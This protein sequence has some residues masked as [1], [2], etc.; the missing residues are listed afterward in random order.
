[1]NQYI[2]IHSARATDLF[3][4]PLGVQVHMQLQHYVWGWLWAFY[5]GALLA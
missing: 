2:K 3:L 4:L 1:M 5:N